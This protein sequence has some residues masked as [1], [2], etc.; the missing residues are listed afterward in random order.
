LI[1]KIANGLS[2]ASIISVA[3]LF[4][5]VF[6]FTGALKEEVK[7]NSKQ[8]EK[9]DNKLDTMLEHLIELGRNLS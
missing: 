1:M 7:T 4:A 3:V 6:M 8:I 5:N 2:I 9:I